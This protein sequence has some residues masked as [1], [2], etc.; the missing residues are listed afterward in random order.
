MLIDER[1][2]LCVLLQDSQNSSEFVISAYFKSPEDFYPFLSL[3]H[4]FI[5]IVLVVVFIFLTIVVIF[6]CVQLHLLSD[7][8]L[9]KLAC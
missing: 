7:Q 6:V 5:P 4:D 9:L 2:Q 1:S 3:S 8:L